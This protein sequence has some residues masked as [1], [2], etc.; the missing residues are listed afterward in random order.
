MGTSTRGLDT[1]YSGTAGLT[2]VGAVAAFAASDQARTITAAD[3]NISRGAIR[4]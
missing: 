3:V 2:D 4:D 1:V